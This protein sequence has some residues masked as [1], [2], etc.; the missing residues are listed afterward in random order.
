MLKLFD[1][2]AFITWETIN[3]K[4]VDFNR[5]IRGLLGI[6]RDKTMD[7]KLMYS[8]SLIIIIYIIIITPAIE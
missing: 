5:N 3:D 2:H 7:D 6:L 1:S 8:T 4:K